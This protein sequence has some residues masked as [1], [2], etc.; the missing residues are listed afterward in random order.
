MASNKIT[1]FK[2]ANN[3]TYKVSDGAA[4]HFDETQNLTTKQKEQVRKNIDAAAATKTY[5]ITITPSNWVTSENTFIYNYFNSAI[6]AIASPIISCTNNNAEYNYIIDA[7]ATAGNSIKFIAK[8]KP[9]ANI[10]LSI[11]DIG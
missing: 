4:V 5:N 11:I 8:K 10:V 2:L 1:K 6:H 9:T 3:Q 7:E